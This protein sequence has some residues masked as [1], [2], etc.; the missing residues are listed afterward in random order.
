MTISRRYAVAILLGAIVMATSYSAPACAQSGSPIKIGVIYPTKSVIGKQGVQGSTIAVDMLN[1]AGGVL[2][3]PVSLVTYDTNYAPVEGVSAVQKLLTQDDVKFVVGEI[4]STVALAVIPVVQ[5]ED[6]VLMLAVPKHPDVTKEGNGNVFRLNTTSAMDA[7]SFDNYLIKDIAP[8]KVAVIAENNDYGRLNVANFKKLF[9]DKLVYSDLFSMTQSD[10]SALVSNLRGSGADLVCIVASNPEHSGNILRGM[11]DLGYN[12][13]R[14][15]TPGLLNN[16]TPK[17]GGAAAEGVFSEDIYSPTIKNELNQK[18]VAAYEKK[19]NETP[20]KIEV[21][22]FETV[23][24]VA[25]AIKAAG[26]DKDAKKVAQTIRAGSW[27]TPRGTVKFDAS[28][29]ASSDTVV[30]VEVR[31]GKV[32]EIRS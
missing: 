29:Q 4:S 3:R 6:A 16:D 28:G 17:I 30:K 9:G 31:D 12:P 15:I 22:G 10:F 23:W 24:I 20:G 18:F 5:A 8:S 2:G 1:A 25:N 27:E 14:C 7:K 19:Y 21:L 32:V 11:K 26:S 13:K